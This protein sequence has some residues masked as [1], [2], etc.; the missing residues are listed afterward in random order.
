MD[1][2]ELPALPRKHLQ[3]NEDLH[4]FGCFN[5]EIGVEYGW[6]SVTDSKVDDFTSTR[7]IMQVHAKHGKEPHLSIEQVRSMWI[8]FRTQI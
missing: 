6:R 3:W 7:F 8:R 2:K 1:P 4:Q 5:R